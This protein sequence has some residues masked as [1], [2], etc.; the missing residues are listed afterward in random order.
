MVSKDPDHLEILQ[1]DGCSIFALPTSINFNNENAEI[2][3]VLLSINRILRY[4]QCKLPSS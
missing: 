3:Q 2:Y 4:V 1:Q